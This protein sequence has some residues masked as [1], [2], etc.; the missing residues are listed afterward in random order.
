MD[1]FKDFTG[2]DLD[3]AIA[4]ACAY[5]D[6]QREQLEV[7]IIQDAKSGIFGLVGA[8][9]AMIK[10][11]RAQ[12]H[13][14][15][16]DT[17]TKVES[18]QKPKKEKVQ[19]PKAAPKQA[20]AQDGSTEKKS[21]TE[22]SQTEKAQTKHSVA[23][24]QENKKSTPNQVAAPAVDK[25]VE[26]SADLDLSTDDECN[27]Q[28]IPFE[29]L[30]QAKLKEVSH[31]VISKLILPIVGM[32][33]IEISFEDARVCISLDCG[34]DSGLLIGREGQTLASL[35]YIVSRIISREMQTSVRVQLDTGD[36]RTRQDEKLRELVLYLADRVRNVGRAHSTR[37][38][39]S[40]HRRIV[41]LV[42]QDCPDLMTRSSGDGP[43]KRVIIQRKRG[44]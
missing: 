4:E 35:Q 9:K 24:S 33:P 2:K 40:Y 44:Q 20:K 3:D 1:N 37:P 14:P 6:T 32:A 12:L 15:I 13:V 41:H 42:L 7:E 38:L 43:L 5:F 8:R 21:Q 27:A 28:R 18:D 22:K 16:G 34:D 31:D 17:S 23:K 26:A 30:D 11:R 36:Y 19:K 10:A 29:E 25:E 39:S